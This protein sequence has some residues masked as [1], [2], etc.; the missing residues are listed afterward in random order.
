[1]VEQPFFSCG[2]MKQ[3]MI[4]I[5][6]SNL[7]MV[8]SSILQLVLYLKKESRNLAKKEIRKGGRISKGCKTQLH[9]KFLRKFV[10]NAMI[11]KFKFRKFEPKK[12]FFT[13]TIFFT[14]Y[15][16]KWHFKKISLTTV[17]R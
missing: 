10:R 6:M 7:T 1:M 15:V 4:N 16:D 17:M 3:A 14:F 5:A 13:K 8:S 9:L 12:H 2:H 11:L